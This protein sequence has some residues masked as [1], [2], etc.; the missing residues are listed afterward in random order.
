MS[1]PPEVERL[2]RLFPI[3]ERLGVYLKGE[4][5]LD[6]LKIGWHCHLTWLTALAVEP[7]IFAGA[8]LFMSECNPETTES[9][10]V[11]DMRA[12]G[13]TIHL[14]P[15]ACKGV[16]EACPEIASDTGLALLSAYL[17]GGHSGLFGSC[18]ITTSGVARLRALEDVPLPVVNINSGRL[19]SQVENF[20]G[21]GDGLIEALARLT[22]ADWNGRRAAVV[23]YGRVGAGAAHYLKRAGVLTTVVETDP[24]LALTAH[25]DGHSLSTLD[26]ALAD[27]ELLVTATG[28]AGL[29]GERQWRLA[30]DGLLVMNVGHFA[31]EVGLDALRSLAAAS[32]RAGAHLEEFLI[33]DERSERRVLVATGGHPVN[34]VLLTGAGEPT[35][36][37]LTTEALSLEYLARMRSMAVDIQP[38]E[39]PVPAE[40]ERQAS[41][42]ALGALGLSAGTDQGIPC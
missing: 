5:F 23:G 31:D 28:R 14:G 3:M 12:R 8:R 22:G 38:G 37:H 7:L 19:K 42:L 2:A 32:A 13:A 41:L 18:E 4:R 40:I 36:L 24:V 9:D 33:R 30:R 29:L 20:H 17:D 16:L 27:S 25:Y 6:G 11:E 10:A 1:A 35:L 34:V 21:V 15:E 26:Q 39:T